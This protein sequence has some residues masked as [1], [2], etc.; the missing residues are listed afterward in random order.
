M[1]NDC[2]Y[3][4]VLSS[5]LSSSGWLVIFIFSPIAHSKHKFANLDFYVISCLAKNLKQPTYI[6]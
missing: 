2:K 1:K 6:L 5:P 3:A 4:S